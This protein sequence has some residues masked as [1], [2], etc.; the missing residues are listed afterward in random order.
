MA[1]SFAAY[2]SQY[3]GRAGAGEPEQSLSSSSQQPLFFSFSTDD[4]S[5]HAHGLD[6][7][8]LDDLDDPHLRE[9][10]SHTVHA[11]QK[12]HD[13]D[14]DE[15]PYLNL[16]EEIP[17]GSSFAGRNRAGESIPLIRSPDS[18]VSSRG[19]SP[20]G[21]LAHLAGSPSPELSTSSSPPPEVF[22]RP[23][24]RNRDLERGEPQSLSLTESLLPRDGHTHH[25][26]SRKRLKHHDTPFLS[27]FLL[28]LSLCVLLCPI[29]LLTTHAP[30]K[31]PKLILPYTTLLHTVPLLTILTFVS[32][33][34]AYAHVWLLRICVGPV[35]VVTEV[36]V[37]LT[38]FG[39]AFYVGGGEEGTWGETVGLRL[40][41]L[42]PLTL[43][44]LSARRLLNLLN[45]STRKWHTNTHDAPSGD[46]PT[47][48][49]PLS[50]LLLIVS[51]LLSIP[52]ITVL[53]RLLLVGYKYGSPPRTEWRLHQWADWA[54]VGVVGVWLWCWGSHCCGVVGSWYFA[55]Q[56]APPPI[57][58]S[59]HII[60]NALT[61]STGPSLGSIALSSLILTLLRLLTLD[62]PYSTFRLIP[63]ALTGVRWTVAY[64]ER[65]TDAMSAY[66]LV[67]VGITGDRF[68]D[69][70]R[71][72]R[73]L[74]RSVEQERGRRVKN[75]PPIS[76]LT[77][78]PLTLT[79]PFAL[80][81]YLFV[82]HTLDAPNQALGAALLAGGVTALVGNFCV[83][84]VEDTVDT[85][86]MCYC[87]DKDAG[88]RRREE[89][90]VIFEY[91]PR[92][93]MNSQPSPPS[94]Q[95]QQQQQQDLFQQ[96][97]IRPNLF[98][99]Q[100]RAPSQIP[101]ARYAQEP[102]QIIPLSPTSPR[103][104][105]FGRGAGAPAPQAQT[106]WSPPQLRQQQ[107]QRAPSFQ[108]QHLPP[109]HAPLPTSPPPESSG[110][111]SQSQQVNSAISAPL[112]SGLT[113][114]LSSQPLPAGSEEEEVD[115]FLSAERDESEAE[116]RGKDSIMRD[117][118]SGEDSD[119]VNGSKA[120]GAESGFFPGSGF[121]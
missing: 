102:E 29:L 118:G 48:H 30:T 84:L 10:E 119:S 95:G 33:G 26:H 40:F 65:V 78:A 32:A 44:I 105:R 22:A 12:V 86:Y 46:I 51:L 18:V 110:L 70:A 25:R 17:G 2:A 28:L 98:Q 104:T 7:Q 39:S 114:T 71:R 21:W 11:P 19:E 68:W 62:V 83:G 103:Q 120:G 79:V 91:D 88:E 6:P 73:A 81:T 16:D 106:Q 94:Q 54:I 93:A 8:D 99:P 34:V 109:K 55:D 117:V 58:S 113:T 47:L 49:P 66:A 60:M 90:F 37:P 75:E 67:Y 96:S 92:R 31:I 15:D 43:S 35:M 87:I 116:G 101:Q 3:L 89:V 63:F 97:P 50:P 53:F 85:L 23:P 5:R 121:F 108:S 20:K 74:V 36:G 1:A 9:S 57:I 56:D 72:S 107:H 41:S 13:E 61:R 100:A 77:V 4:G 115:P 14:D 59:T 27:L 52:F 45:A 112:N 82:A 42:I 38:L 80:L 64:I 24:A 69:S 111:S 76:L